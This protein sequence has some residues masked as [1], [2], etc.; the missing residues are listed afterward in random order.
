MDAGA[1]NHSN[2][3]K[4]NLKGRFPFRLGTTSYII[5]DD[6]I[7]NL[8][9]LANQ[10]DD[11]ELVLFESDEFSNIPHPADVDTMHRLAT[12]YGLT[13][14]V[15]LPLDIRLGSAD[16]G[17]RQASIGKCL[18]VME[19]MSQLDPF[20]W[21]LHLH[22][23]QRGETPS[24]NLPVWLSQNRRSLEEI[25]HVTGS[26]R[27]ICVETL[28]YDFDLVAALIEDLDLAV[29]L[30]I[31]HLIVMKR[32]VSGHLDRWLDRT[33][34]IHLHGVR[35]TKDHVDLSHLSPVM[36]DQIIGRLSRPS[37][38]NRVLTLEIFGESDFTNSMEILE[39]R[40]TYTIPPMSIRQP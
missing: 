33:R 34:V 2:L 28:D 31:G 14:T 30:D 13:Y 3:P 40:F 10:V 20:G 16:E 29:C 25:I 19:R 22:G 7:P 32:S 15:H 23:D 36:L 11:V 8:H 24:D 38:I 6:I 1:S 21:I 17:E 9:Y 35:E 26:T 12:S 5:P 18:R 37:Q 27:S 39:K 4:H